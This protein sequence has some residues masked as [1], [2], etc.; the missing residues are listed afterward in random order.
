MTL[1]GD[2]RTE[3]LLHEREEYTGGRRERMKGEASGGNEG[4]ELDFCEG[5]RGL[6]VFLFVL[7]VFNKL[8]WCPVNH[9][10]T[11]KYF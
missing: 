2:G 8:Y 11:K 4:E 1:V 3:P 6:M 10:C 7:L 9:K 5:E